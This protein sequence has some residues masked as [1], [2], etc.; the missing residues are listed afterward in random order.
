MKRPA[1]HRVKSDD[2][3]AVQL[4][5]TD[6]NQFTNP[7]ANRA[8]PGRGNVNTGS[9]DAPSGIPPPTES[10]DP[11]LVQPAQAIRVGIVAMYQVATHAS[12][13]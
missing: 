11:C 5:P 8:N 13:H 6:S 2:S 1:P 7:E 12:P 10:S 4:A 3:W 9:P